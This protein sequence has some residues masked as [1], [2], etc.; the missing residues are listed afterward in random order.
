MSL[1]FDV[2][3]DN[4]ERLTNELVDKSLDVQREIDT[5]ND[6]AKVL[7]ASAPLVTVMVDGTTFKDIDFN[8]FDMTLGEFVTTHLERVKEARLI[9]YL[10]TKYDG[11]N[12]VPMVHLQQELQATHEEMK[13]VNNHLKL[14]L[15]KV[16]IHSFIPFELV[17]VIVMMQDED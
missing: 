8:Y 9:K 17:A 16:D 1:G 6:E 5:I 2:N 12:G 10:K 4:M 7:E 13:S 15:G 11:F 14:E 3:T